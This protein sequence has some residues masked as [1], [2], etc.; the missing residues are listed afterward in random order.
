MSIIIGGLYLMELNTYV[1]E[2]ATT[3]YAQAYAW[4]KTWK[5]CKLENELVISTNN[6]CSN[7]P[8][9][10]HSG[11]FSI[12]D[13]NQQYIMDALIVRDSNAPIVNKIL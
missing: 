10:S 2:G 4:A 13:N 5:E 3:T 6:T 11:I 8:I 1:R 12:I 9:P 7:N